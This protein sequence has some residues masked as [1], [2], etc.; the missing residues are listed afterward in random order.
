MTPPVAK[1]FDRRLVGRLG[2]FV[3]PHWRLLVLALALIPVASVLEMTLPYLLKVAVDEH[4]ATRE[5]AGLLALAVL[6]AACTVGRSLVGMAQ[7]YLLGLLG[8][9]TMHDLRCAVHAHVLGRNAT[10]FDRT[11][12]GQ[13]LNSVTSNIEVVNQLFV[14]GVVTVIADLVVLIGLVGMMFYL[15]A[16]LT[17]VTL[18][19]VPL[20]GPLFAWSR[21]ILRV[22]FRSQR[23]NQA[24]LH[25]FIVEHIS[26]LPTV[27][28]FCRERRAAREHATRGERYRKAALDSVKATAVALPATEAIA[29]VSGAFVIW[30][31]GLGET[32]LTVGLVVAFV[33]YA[34][35]LFSP[36]HA[37]AQKY[38]TMQA[39]MAAAERI[40]ELLDTQEADAPAAPH[41]Q[42]ATAAVAPVIEL[43]DV[44][45]GYRA[46]QP[47]LH[48]ISLQVP[49]GSTIAVVGATGSGKS[50]LVRLLTRL[51][52]PQAGTIA[53]DGRDVRAWPVHE[54]RRRLTVIP[55]DVFLFTG[56]IAD[57]VRVGRAS[58]SL[59]EIEACLRQVGAARL[60]ERGLGAEVAERG[61]NL[62]TGERQLIAFARALIRDPDILLLDEATANVDPETEQTI[63]RAL[64]TLFSGRTS[65]IV[66]HR[67]S[68]IRRADRIVVLSHGRVVEHGTRDELLAADGVYRRLEEKLVAS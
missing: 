53:I 42:V 48:G 7:S 63:E 57:N 55:Q 30:Y 19:L 39:A 31:G 6:Y 24:E 46:D 26:G 43:R 62:S 47:V 45:F 40:F 9:R 52:E 65:L 15:H 16:E 51:Y 56:T 10:F 12:V 4:I 23:A 11:P 8:Q 58:A 50:T 20:L 33:E 1:A 29:V 67:L 17:L 36:V 44:V 35:R 59:D 13:L 54:L 14:S 34:N 25:A 28:T 22:A 18:V 49:K 68:T 32:A 64:V 5:T 27:Q 38:V 37:L 60:L 21:R 2:R 41:A 61:A 66:A 3:R